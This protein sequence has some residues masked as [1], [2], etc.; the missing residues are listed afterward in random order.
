MQS[1]IIEVH[2]K[3]CENQMEEH[4]VQPLERALERQSGYQRLRYLEVKEKGRQ[5]HRGNGINEESGYVW[6]HW[7][8]VL[9]QGTGYS[10]K[11][12]M[13]ISNCILDFHK[14]S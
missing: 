6:S 10:N 14:Y 3:D 2:L 11:L 7:L 5:L 12:S 9:N 13:M 4:L 8:G 1:Y